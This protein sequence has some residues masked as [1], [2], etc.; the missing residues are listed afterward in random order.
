MLRPGSHEQLGLTLVEGATRRES[1]EC[2]GAEQV[3]QEL[4]RREHWPH[5]LEGGADLVGRPRALAHRSGVDLVA[6]AGRERVEQGLLDELA[7]RVVRV[8][9]PARTAHDAT[10]RLD[11]DPEPGEPE[12]HDE[13]ARE[14]PL[15]IADRVREE[16]RHAHIALD[17][18]DA[19]ASVACT[20]TAGTRS[21][22][23][24]C[25]T[26]VSPSEGRTRWM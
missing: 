2:G 18:S 25:S 15:P 8:R 10:R 12:R 17:P 13:V 19:V 4:R 1:H 6:A 14:R 21:A 16:G 22:S 9:A 3:V 5:R 7:A 11:V 26:P 24:T 23:T 20:F